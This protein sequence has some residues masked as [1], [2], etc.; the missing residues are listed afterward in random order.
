MG[1]GKNG[2]NWSPVEFGTSSAMDRREPGGESLKRR[3]EVQ[4]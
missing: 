3:K 4:S 2:L 1:D